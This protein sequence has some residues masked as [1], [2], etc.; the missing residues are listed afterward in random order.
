MFYIARQNHFPF[1]IPGVEI[2]LV[3]FGTQKSSFLAK[4]VPSGSS[5]GRDIMCQLSL[6]ATSAILWAAFM[7]ASAGPVIVMSYDIFVLGKSSPC[8]VLH[9]TLSCPETLPD[10]HGCGEATVAQK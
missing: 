4:V 6:F 9:L 7:I 10:L 8:Q 3:R 5:F 1:Q 2:K